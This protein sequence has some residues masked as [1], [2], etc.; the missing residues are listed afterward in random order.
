MR[1]T[2]HPRRSTV[3]HRGRGGVLAVALIAV[4]AIVGGACRPLPGGGNPP[5]MAQPAP[6]QS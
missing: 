6:D 5:P 4:L 2:T 3:R 1:T